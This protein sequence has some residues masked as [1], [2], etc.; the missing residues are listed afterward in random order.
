M[1]QRSPPCSAAMLTRGNNF[2]EEHMLTRGNNFAEEHMLNY[3]LKTVFKLL[4]TLLMSNKF[5]TYEGVVH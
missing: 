2:A 5:E 1:R 4:T 3:L